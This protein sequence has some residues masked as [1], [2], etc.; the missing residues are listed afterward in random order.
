MYKVY[1]KINNDNFVISVFSTCF[2]E[3]NDDDIFIKKGYGDEFI[4]V[5]GSYD[6][7]HNN[8]SYRYKIIDGNMVEVNEQ[9]NENQLTEFEMLTNKIDILE[10]GLKSILA[11]DMQ[12]LA[13]LL[14]PNDFINNEI[15][16]IP[17]L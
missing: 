15:T 9:E 11:G 1:A 16:T 5:Q 14:Y 2:Y 4:H 12:S 10:T 17:E 8:G 7:L 3:P 6:L 13:Y